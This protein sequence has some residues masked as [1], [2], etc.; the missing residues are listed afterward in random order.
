MP[1]HDDEIT[2][3]SVEARDARQQSPALEAKPLK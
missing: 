3:V 2:L 1:S